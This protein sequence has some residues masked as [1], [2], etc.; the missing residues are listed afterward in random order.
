M[1]VQRHYADLADVTIHY[2]TAGKGEP[3]VLLHGIPQTSHEWRHIIPLLADQYLIIAP[4]LRGLGDSLRPRDGY[5]KKTVSGDV[6][7][8]VRR[9][10]GIDRFFLAEHDWGGPTAFALAMQHRETVRR[11]A[12][13][14]VAFPGGGDFSQG[15]RRW[16]QL[17]RSSH[18]NDLA[19]L[20][21]P[22]ILPTIVRETTK[23][24]FSMPSEPLTGSLLR[25]L[26][27]AK[28]G[29]RLLELGTG[30]GLS[31]A[32]LLDGM[33]QSAT[34]IS[35]DADPKVQA[36]AQQYLGSDSR[37]RLVTADGGLF[38]QQQTL[39]SFDLIFADA[40]PG[41][42]EFL[43]EAL[44][45]LRPGGLYVIDD[46]LPQTNWPAGHAPKVP[47]LI[48]DLASRPGF[49]LA[50]LAWSSGLVIATRAA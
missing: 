30:T 42:Y 40:M 16:H 47:N 46:M 20:S 23:L 25:V 38:L 45:L 43:D 17:L 41:K 36:I 19:H 31:T 6:W 2:L 26:A 27:A 15:G 48:A 4:D 8:L 24:G 32:W 21:P 1:D 50:T 37:L 18:M 9:H 12:I 39:E 10:L 13:L 28:P 33:D 34:L 3:L 5:D 7:D 22:S 44:T 49:H 14:D 29:A 11:L 35:V